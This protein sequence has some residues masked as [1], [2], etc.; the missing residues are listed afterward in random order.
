MALQNHTFSTMTPIWERSHKYRTYPR[1][2]RDLNLTLV[3]PTLKS[4]RGEESPRRLALKSMELTSR[5]PK[6]L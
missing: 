4:F 3:T 2:V 6:I 5:R 1:G